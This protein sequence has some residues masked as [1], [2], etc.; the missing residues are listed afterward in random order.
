[1]TTIA[2][3]HGRTLLQWD[4]NKRYLPVDIERVA[5]GKGQPLWLCQDGNYF[6]LA[7]DAEVNLACKLVS[8]YHN[9]FCYDPILNENYLTNVRSR[10]ESSS[11][12]VNSYYSGSDSDEQE[13][14]QLPEPVQ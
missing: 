8:T 13:Y 2:W 4:R 11:T 12:L 3:G 7:H 5:R 10:Y 6:L 1:M 14:T 9:Q